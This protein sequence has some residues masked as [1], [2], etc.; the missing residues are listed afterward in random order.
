MGGEALAK[1]VHGQVYKNF[2]TNGP[3][4]VTSLIEQHQSKFLAA[5][6][7]AKDEN[8]LVAILINE[9]SQPK[10]LAELADQVL[11]MNRDAIVAELQTAALK[12]A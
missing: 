8:N 9:I 2:V 1:F 7:Q 12:A 6:S 5:A 10:Y 4:I 11:E 3:K